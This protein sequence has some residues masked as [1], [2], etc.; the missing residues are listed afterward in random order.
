MES[1]EEEYNNRFLDTDDWL[2]KAKDHL[3]SAEVLRKRIFKMTEDDPDAG[4][5]RPLIISH[6]F[7]IGVALENSLKGFIIYSEKGDMNVAELQKFIFKKVSHNL[8][9]YFEEYCPDIYKNNEEVIKRGEEFVKWRGKYELPRNSEEY[10]NITKL[11]LKDIEK[12][13]KINETLRVKL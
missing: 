4:N 1:K 3:F 11:H 7:L 8:A 10:K 6:F 12:V 13:R 9:K 5:V 2:E